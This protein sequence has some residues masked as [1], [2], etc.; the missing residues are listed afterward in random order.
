MKSSR[1]LVVLFTLALLSQGTA[2]ELPSFAGTWKL[3]TSKGANLGMMAAMQSTLT[4]EQTA[5]AL[6][7]KEVS[8]FQGQKTEREIHYDLAGK[9]VSNPNA[10]GG[11]GETVAAWLDGKL[12]VTWTSE[13]AVAGTKTIRTETRS[14]ST[15][16]LTMT[17]ESVRGTGK[18]VVMV[19]EKKK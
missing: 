3:D 2:A 9:P 12:V 4:I 6:A 17:V 15:D 10:M 8:E 19:Y 5:A 11:S 13:G 16:G 14:L 1:T 18:P 7:I